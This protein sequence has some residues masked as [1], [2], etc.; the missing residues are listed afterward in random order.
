MKENPERFIESNTED[1]W[2]EYLS[3]MAK[4]GTWADGLIIQAVADKFHLKIDIVETNPGLPDS[5]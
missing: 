1:S 4:Q 5:M 3:N 2:I